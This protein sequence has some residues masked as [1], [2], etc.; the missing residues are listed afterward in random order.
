M[1][2]YGSGDLA[3]SVILCLLTRCLVSVLSFT[4]ELLTS[5]PSEP[6]QPEPLLPAPAPTST[7]TGKFELTKEEEDELAELLDSD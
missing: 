7:S 5:L 6:P 4:S 3:V 2:R 1:A